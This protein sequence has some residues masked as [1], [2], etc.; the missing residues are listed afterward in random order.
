MTTDRE[1]SRTIAACRRA[2]LAVVDEGDCTC[3][4]RGQLVVLARAGGLQVV[5]PYDQRCPIHGAP[6][7]SA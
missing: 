2:G 5:W 1:V 6:T 3:R 7:T 4:L